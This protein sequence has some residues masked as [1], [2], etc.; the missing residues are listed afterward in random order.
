VESHVAV[1]VLKTRQIL[2]SKIS[3]LRPISYVC[4]SPPI[5]HNWIPILHITYYFHIWK[6]VFSFACMHIIRCNTSVTREPIFA[7]KTPWENTR[8]IPV[9]RIGYVAKPHA[10]GGGGEGGWRRAADGMA[11]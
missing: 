3:C 5:P 9:L 6:V 1:L 4:V 11:P 10:V 7:P 8:E 2:I